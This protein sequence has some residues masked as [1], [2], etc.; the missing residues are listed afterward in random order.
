MKTRLLTQRLLALFAAGWLLF[1]YPL[2]K[3]WL[4][5]ATVFGWPLLPLALF[6]AWALLL[7]LLAWWM[8]GDG[9]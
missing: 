8:E 6:G 7:G 2:L 4:G 1:N 5:G 9:D 3:L